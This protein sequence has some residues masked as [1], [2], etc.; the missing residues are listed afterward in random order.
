M[1]PRSPAAKA[2]NEAKRKAA[3]RRRAVAPAKP[4]AAVV[5][6]SKPKPRKVPPPTRKG[7]VERRR[8]AVTEKPAAAK[9]PRRHP[10]ASKAGRVLGSNGSS[11]DERA[12]AGSVLA[13]SDDREK[14]QE[15]VTSLQGTVTSL[16]RQ[17][18]E[19]GVA[20]E[21]LEAANRSL[22][23]EIG[24]LGGEVERLN[25]L[26]DEER[27]AHEQ[28]KQEAREFVSAKAEL[29]QQVVEERDKAN[30]KVETLTAELEVAKS[31]D[32]AAENEKL[33]EQLRWRD[34]QAST[35][36]Q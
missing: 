28:S 1:A 5:P 10:V 20:V 14:Q 9:A 19:Q 34:E 3:V 26:L 11:P 2:E 12:V 4:R 23:E 17:L 21:T 7:I 16:E 13:T 35:K 6:A 27:R 24:R 30:A 33:K 29:Y 22:Q 18:G 36:R 31:T 15:A 32:L 25:G 8:P